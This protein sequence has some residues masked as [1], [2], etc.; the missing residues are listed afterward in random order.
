MRR[1]GFRFAVSMAVV[2][3]LIAATGCDEGARAG[4]LQTKS[5]TVE[6]GDDESLPTTL[7]SSIRW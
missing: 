6:L 2:V 4:D 5:E 1:Q 3:V 7:T